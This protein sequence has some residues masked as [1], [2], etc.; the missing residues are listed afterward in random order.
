MH[1]KVHIEANERGYAYGDDPNGE[2]NIDLEMSDDL[3]ETLYLGDL[4]GAA[5]MLA[6][7]DYKKAL[8]SRP[9]DESDTL[10]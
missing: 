10:H 1:I 2:Q 5:I 7:K 3:A 9:V 8:E 6:V 4:I